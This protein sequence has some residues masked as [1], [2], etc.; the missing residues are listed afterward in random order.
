MLTAINQ[1]TVRRI[2]M[3]AEVHARVSPA[4]RMPH[5]LGRDDLLLMVGRDA[6]R[7]SCRRRVHAVPPSLIAFLGTGDVVVLELPGPAEVRAFYVAPGLLADAASLPIWQRDDRHTDRRLV[8]VIADARLCDS[9]DSVKSADDVAALV[10]QTATQGSRRVR[11]TSREPI[12]H[13]VVWRA[14]DHLRQEYARRVTLDE[15][16]AV[17]G[18]RR[19]ALAHAFTR[20]VGMPPHAYQTHVRV[21]RARELI[22]KGQLLSSVSQ[23]VGFADQSHLT[24]H[25]KRV[26]GLTP[27]RYV[28]AV[29]AGG[30][31]RLAASASSAS[32]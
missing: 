22:G 5:V 10:E 32:A 14:R 4:G 29:N 26:L 7:L 23:Q 18:M 19:F 1:T 11:L 21:H 30:S 15:L 27:G 16:A 9:A 25:F 17:V 2:G 12:S 6:A 20:E 8:W 3:R 24:R 13:P 28:R 31:T